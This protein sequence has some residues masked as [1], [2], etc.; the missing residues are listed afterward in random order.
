MKFKRYV[1]KNMLLVIILTIINVFLLRQLH[2]VNFNFFHTKSLYGFYPTESIGY[3]QIEYEKLSVT[4]EAEN[5]QFMINV[6]KKID[7]IAKKVKLE[8]M[9]IIIWQSED[10]SRY[11]P[12]LLSGKFFSN[13]V[14]ENQVVI[15]KQLFN[16][17]AEEQ[18]KAL[19][20]TVLDQTY[21]II[22]V[23]GEK[24]V[25]GYFDNTLFVPLQCAPVS[26]LKFNEPN[27]I[28]DEFIA[29]Q[30]NGDYSEYNEE[31][32]KYYNVTEVLHEIA[33]NKVLSVSQTIT[34]S[35]ETTMGLLIILFL[36]LTI[37]I[38]DRLNNQQYNLAVRQVMGAKKTALFQ[39]IM[40]EYFGIIFYALSITYVIQRLDIMF[41]LGYIRQSLP[42]YYVLLIV[43]Q[44]VIFAFISLIAIF[45]LAR[46][47][48]ALGVKK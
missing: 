5:K 44:F 38:S 13:Q 29:H 42:Y 22:G 23:L 21:D 36:T 47:S 43:I 31:L 3:N 1:R 32:K 20:I 37:M 6:S 35:L 15:G 10:N 46:I 30:F 2:L 39:K 4:S 26:L 33:P 40:L 34:K 45:K 14:S 16:Q 12:D 25:N 18:K 41:D 8:K 28:Y 48:P 7:S 17:L 11:S 27:R 19:Q 24:G 9:D